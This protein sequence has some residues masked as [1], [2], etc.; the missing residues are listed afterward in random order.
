[1]PAK[2]AKRYLIV[3]AD[4]FGQSH[5]INRGIIE[6]HEQGIVTSASLMV[7][8]PAAAE[9]AAYGR[10]QPELSLGLHL[11]FSEWTCRRGAWMP[12][13]EVVPE[14]DVEAVAR[15]T[16]RQ[17]ATFR[18][19]LGR[20]PTHIDSHQHAH[21]G[22]Q[23]ASIFLEIAARLGVPLRGCTP[24]VRYFGGFYGQSSNGGP[25]PSLI[26]VTA[27]IRILAKL[28]PGITELSC[29]PGKGNGLNSMYLRE[30][31]KEVKTLCDPQVRAAIA[32]LGI[33][34]CSFHDLRARWGKVGLAKAGRR[35]IAAKRRA[36]A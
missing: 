6:A 15:E 12:L 27:L 8:W 16:S 4:D 3:N 18:R 10:K 7:R 17:L 1:M 9:A 29:H 25:L 35:G 24:E 32:D 19:L 28:R 11:D 20:D 5:G 33:E 14:D 30:R 13:Y 26:S 34:L 2:R 22:R 36:V 31:A 21:R 23:V